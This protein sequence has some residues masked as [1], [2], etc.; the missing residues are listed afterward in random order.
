MPGCGENVEEGRG[1]KRGTGG[2]HGIVSRSRCWR[3]ACGEFDC[4]VIPCETRMRIVRVT[5]L[6]VSAE[7]VRRMSKR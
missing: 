2:A 5:K 4:A 7:I 3:S 1:A 6:A